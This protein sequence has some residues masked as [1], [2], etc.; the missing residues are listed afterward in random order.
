MS[1]EVIRVTH[2]CSCP[3]GQGRIIY[4]PAMNDWNQFM[5]GKTE[6]ECPKCAEN[7]YFCAEGGLIEKGFP[8]YKGDETLKIEINMLQNQIDSI[9]YGIFKELPEEIQKKRIEQFFTIDELSETDKKKKA[10]INYV[11]FEYSA[12]LCNDYSIDELQN[13]LEQLSSVKY[14]TQLFGLAK[15]IAIHHNWRFKT[16]KPKN[17]IYPVQVA[18]RNYFY[19]LQAKQEDE[20]LILQIQAKLKPLEDV[21]YKDYPRYKEERQKHIFKY[22]LKKV[23]E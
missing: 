5:D 13:V 8:S 20:E 18:I 22:E 9:K 1:Y 15:D 16:I 7:Y 17:V 21:Y 6:I 19:Y 10:Y 12:Q 4:G 14:S 2:A 23:D 11:V 3:C